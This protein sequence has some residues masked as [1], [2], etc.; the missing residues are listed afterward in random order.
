MKA[1]I[2]FIVRHNHWFL[3]VLLEVV[4]VVLLFR[5]N[6]YQGSAWFT[7]ANTVA[8][9]MYE[10]DS[11]IGSYFSLARLNEQLTRENA[12]LELKMGQ[13]SQQ[14]ADLTH[15][16][17]YLHPSA[18]KALSGY[19]LIDAKVITNSL[20]KT[21]NLMTIDKGLADGVKKDMG[22]V[23]GKGIVGIVYQTTAHYAVV[24]SVLNSRSNISCAIQD[25]GYFGTLRWNG[26]N[27]SVA[28][29]DDIPRHAKFRTG[30]N[31]VTSG[32]SSIFPPGVKVGTIQSF[33]NSANGLAY[34]LKVRL[35]TDFGN[36]R[37]VCVIDNAPMQE[38]LQL[39]RAAQDSLI[40]K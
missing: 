34:E 20:D 29:V 1:L 18:Q 39:L 3:F 32:Y 5:Y 30:E 13:M 6:S 8:G 7:T 28:S 10:L 40:V 25:C 27:P 17:T 26:Q 21:D 35:A 23:S 14:L 22:V 31:V 33:S 38:R 19:K 24:M 11:K 37:D 9:K 4:S 2:E 16:S 36:L 12:E 15:D